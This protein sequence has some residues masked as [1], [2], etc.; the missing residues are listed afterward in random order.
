MAKLLIIDDEEKM[1]SM[2][3]RMLSP[4]YEVVQARNGREGLELFHQHRPALVITDIMMPEADG[5]ETIR[6][7][8]KIDPQVAVIAI[9]GSSPS[10]GN[11]DFLKFAAEF[12]A[13]AILAKPFRAKQL[14][15][16]VNRALRPR[17][18]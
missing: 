7:I 1:R 11:P 18:A 14:I 6:E 16:A 15:D 2:I 12:G 4:P 8:R 17:G 9:S 13:N 3:A 10:D 5:I